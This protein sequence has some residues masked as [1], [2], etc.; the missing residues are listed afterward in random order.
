MH[1]LTAR[2]RRDSIVV[3]HLAAALSLAARTGSSRS[4]EVVVTAELRERELRQSAR[5]R[6]RARRAHARDRGRAAFPGRARARAEPQLVVAGTSRPRFF[7][8]RGIGELEQWQGAPNPS[9]GFLIDGIDFSGIGMPATLFDVERIEVLR[10]PQGT[11]YGANALA[12]LISVST[13]APRREPECQ[14]EACGRRLRHAYGVERCVG[15]PDRRWRSAPGVS[16]PANIEA[17][18]SAATPSCDRDDTNGYD[19]SSARLRLTRAA[20]GSVARRSHRDVG[21][22]R[23]RLRRVLDRQ[24][25]HDALRQARP[26]CA[27]S[28]VPAPCVSTTAVPSAFDVISRTAIRRLATSSIRSTATGATTRLGHD[29][30]PT[31]TSQRFDR[32]RRTLS[33]DL[34]LVSR[35]S[36][37][38]GADFAWLAGVYAVAHRRGSQAVRRVARPLLRGRR[39]QLASDYRATNLAAYGEVDW[40][41]AAATVLTVGARVRATAAPTTRTPTARHSPRT[42]PCS[43]VDR[44]CAANSANG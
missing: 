4:S 26:G 33:E 6:H 21:R 39:S 37:D 35:A 2:H 25:A 38:E 13:R 31:T 16:A 19:E 24:L 17:T 42:R 7:Q 3:C 27:A 22:S 32:D 28:P 10:G 20:A 14:R 29:I 40:R 5:Q 43:A 34:R 36:V 15:R 44:A 1:A 41:L 8:L 30:R 12:G 11:A 9:V 18:A 23:Q